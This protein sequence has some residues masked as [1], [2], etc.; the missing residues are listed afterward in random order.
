M[1]QQSRWVF[2]IKDQVVLM[3]RNV[4]I[5][6]CGIMQLFG[7]AQM[8]AIYL[9]NT[10]LMKYALFCLFF[11]IEWDVNRVICVHLNEVNKACLFTKNEKRNIMLMIVNT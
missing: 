7:T 2:D 8:P 4:H 10:L 1:L 11:L 3:I 6:L 9:M 5:V